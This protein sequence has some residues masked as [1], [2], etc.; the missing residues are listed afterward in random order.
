MQFI[1]LINRKPLDFDF[2]AAPIF[3]PLFTPLFIPEADLKIPHINNVFAFYL[4]L[5]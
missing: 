1:S 3:T 5:N 4:A 2:A